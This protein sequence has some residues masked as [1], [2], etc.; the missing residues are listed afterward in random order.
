MR[1]LPGYVLCPSRR[2]FTLIETLV[3]IGIIGILFALIL[4]AVQSAREAGRRV[5]CASNLRQLGLAQHAYHD[6]HRRFA[7][8]AIAAYSAANS[9]LSVNHF[10]EHV[11]LLPYLD[12]AA[13]YQ[14]VN[15]DL[16]HTEDVS[17]PSLHNRTARRTLVAAF[18]CPSDGQGDRRN[19]YRFNGGRFDTR[20]QKTPFDGPFSVGVEP[21]PSAFR[22]GLSQT[23]FA[24]EVVSGDFRPGSADRVRN[25]RHPST[26][27]GEVYRADAEYIPFCL[28]HEAPL[29]GSTSGRYWFYTTFAHTKYNHNGTPNDRRPSCRMGAIRN[30]PGGLTPPRSF[31]GGVAHV[32]FGDGRVQ[33]VAD[34]IDPATWAALGTHSS[35][36]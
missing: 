28:G 33:A 5:Q 6:V 26:P 2:G 15:M 35:G 29:W 17:F 20:P 22:D 30:W 23:A 32:L 4:P 7:S 18:L 16:A 25:V 3:A 14:H 31:H 10:A 9:P 1:I 21:T 13:L 12:Q 8:A 19:N 34:A 24:S 27:K 11:F 36:D